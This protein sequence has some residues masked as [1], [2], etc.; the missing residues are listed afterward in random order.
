MGNAT[1]I[2][3]Q[4]RDSFGNLITTSGGA[5]INAS[6]GAGPNAGATLTIVDVGDGTYTITYTAASG[7]GDDL[8]DITLSAVPIGGSPYTNSI[9]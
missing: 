2:T 3:V 1:T 4:L 6:I 9:Q 8:V 5:I 7:P